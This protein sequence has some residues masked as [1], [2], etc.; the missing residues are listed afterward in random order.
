MVVTAP[1]SPPVRWNLSTLFNGIDDP[2]IDQV[3]EGVLT[4]ADVFAERYRGEIERDQIDPKLLLEA[5]KEIEAIYQEASKPACFASLLFAADTSNAAIGAFLQRQMERNTELGVKLLFFELELQAAPEE[6]V[7]HALSDPSLASYR[8]YVESTR[9]YSPYRLSEKEEII[10]EECANTGARAFERLFEEVTSSHTYKYRRPPDGE[11][12]SLSMPGV[13]NLLRDPNRAIRQA[14]ADSFTEGLQEISRVLIF[15][16]NT[17]LQDKAVSDRLRGYGTPELSRH[18]SN[19]LKAETVDLVM[20][21][22]NRHHGLVER[23][24]NVKRE[25]LGLEELT[26]VDRYAPLWDAEKVVTWEEAQD[27]VLTSFH[28]FSPEI[29]DRAQEFFDKEWIDAE[30]RPGKRGGAFC[31]YVT[32][33][34]HPYVFLNFLCKMDQVG[35]LAHELGHGVHA[36]LSREQSL[37]NFHGTLPLAELASTFG[38]M[39]VFERLVSQA[40]LRD[41]IALYAEKIEGVFATVFRQAAMYGFEREC[42]RLRR[43]EGE[44]S[45]ERFGD[46]WQGQMQAMFGNSVRLGDQHRFWWSYIPHFIRSPFYVYAYS[47]GELLV[48]S[49]YQMAKAEGPSFADRYVSLL[50]KGGSQSPDALMASIG[51]DLQSEAFWLSGFS[52]LEKLI[53][54][55]E[56]RWSE[57]RSQS[58]S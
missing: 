25:I 42:H 37:F 35:T 5:I 53:H 52:A 2:R 34:T 15:C 24:Y 47:F 43:E 40:D 12:E 6:A 17:L 19:E 8:H 21:L 31:S 46:I 41:S 9:A 51:I 23:F 39:L 58:T 22:C 30:W 38:E 33:D 54:D 20:D 16:Y 56:A 4:R 10:L 28:A 14:A 50:R 48:L 27:I 55:F 1:A 32:P 18:L 26:H 36:S 44:L 7:R 45:A 3:W 29:A 49:L 13:I 11:V 57:L